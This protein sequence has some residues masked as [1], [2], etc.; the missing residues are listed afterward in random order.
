M[1]SVYDLFLNPEEKKASAPRAPRFTP[2]QAAERLRSLGASGTTT[3]SGPGTSAPS[4]R[5]FGAV[6]S[7]GTRAAGLLRGATIPGL[8]SIAVPTVASA[9]ASDRSLLK[10]PSAFLQD[11]IGGAK[12][13]TGGTPFDLSPY[14]D[15]V[16]QFFGAS[17]SPADAAAARAAKAEQEA[18]KNRLPAAPVPDF[19]NAI[20]AVPTP[21]ARAPSADAGPTQAAQP[22]SIFSRSLKTFEEEVRARAALGELT[23]DG[24][25]ITADLNVPQGAGLFVNNTTGRTQTLQA[26]GPVASAPVPRNDLAAPV[27]DTPYDSAGVNA[28]IRY[29]VARQQQARTDRLASQEATRQNAILNAVIGAGG[30]TDA[31]TIGAD[32]RVR[33]A[34]IAADRAA[35]IEAEKLNRPKVEIQPGLTPGDPGRVVVADPRSGAAVSRP[36]IEAPPPGMSVADIDAQTR[37]AAAAG[38]DLKT[39]NAARARRGLGPLGTK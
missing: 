7:A 4:V 18:A 19:T 12:N 6:S 28:A 14:A 38:D 17:R 15:R 9:V 26:P 27:I 2:E 24:R 10:D 21:G 33:A 29:T 37:E 32:A 8:A 11:L 5:G 23:P 36:V 35:R 1:P 13:L 30:R 39:I 25:A 3:V 16:R 20:T 34:E 22:D 31:A